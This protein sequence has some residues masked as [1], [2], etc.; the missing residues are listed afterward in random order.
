MVGR[1]RIVMVVVSAPPLSLAGKPR[2]EDNGGGWNERQTHIEILYRSFE[3]ETA[4]LSSDKLLLCEDFGP[5]LEYF[6]P[7]PT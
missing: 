7:A 4:N 5:V 3:T 6:R 1:R 2:A